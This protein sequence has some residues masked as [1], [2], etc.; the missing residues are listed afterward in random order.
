MLRLHSEV[1]INS[2]QKQTLKWLLKVMQSR[3]WNR[4]CPL[5]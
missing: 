5:C 1:G 4:K 3:S 2:R